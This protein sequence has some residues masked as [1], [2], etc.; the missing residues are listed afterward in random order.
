[1]WK[2]DMDD[3][4]DTKSLISYAYCSS[5]KSQNKTKK[6]HLDQL[7]AAFPSD[8]SP[9]FPVETV[10]FSKC[11]IFIDDREDVTIINIDNQSFRNS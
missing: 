6:K 11:L 1:M 9:S 10:A 5:V 3:D 4:D 8:N 2:R 7:Y